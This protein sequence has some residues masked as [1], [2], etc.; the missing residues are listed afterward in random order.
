MTKKVLFCRSEGI[1]VLADN[2]TDEMINNYNQTINFIH[3]RTNAIKYAEKQLKQ[4]RNDAERFYELDNKD[5]KEGL[6]PEEQE[7]W[8]KLA[9][10]VYGDL[11]YDYSILK[12]EIRFEDEE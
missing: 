8:R 6:N 12:R 5:N 7:E 2:V 10:I 3:M 9:P 1:K 11:P 4:W